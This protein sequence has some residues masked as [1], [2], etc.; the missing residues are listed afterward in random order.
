MKKEEEAMEEMGRWAHE[1]SFTKNPQNPSPFLPGSG[2]VR[3][4]IVLF[5]VCEVKSFD[6]LL[7]PTLESV[8]E[9]Q[10]DTTT[11]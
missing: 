3:S 2:L 4:D 9:E 6:I 7:V 1:V 10:L 8:W 5:S 11:P